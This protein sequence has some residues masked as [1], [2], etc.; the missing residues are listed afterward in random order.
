MKQI[1][2]MYIRGSGQLI[3]W[4]KSSIFFVNTPEDKQRKIAR[5]LG[6]GVGK[7]PSTYLG[8]SFGSTPPDSFWN[9]LLNRFNKKLVD[10]KATSLSQVGKF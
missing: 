4:D 8:L 5:I 10:W 2:D 7:L 6:C 3:N 1:L 9:G